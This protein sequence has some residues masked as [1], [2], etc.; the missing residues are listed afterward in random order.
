MQAGL[1][2]NLSIKGSGA[3]SNT[4]FGFTALRV[5]KPKAVKPS[6]VLSFGSALERSV[7]VACIGEGVSV[8]RWGSRRFMNQVDTG[9]PLTA[10][11]Y[12]H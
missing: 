8:K 1:K 7:C 4:A 12:L 5:T 10:I 6:V 11:R 9:K 3:V 2:K